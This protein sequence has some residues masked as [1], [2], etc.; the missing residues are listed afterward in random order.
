[1]PAVPYMMAITRNG[2]TAYVICD[3][4]AA[5]GAPQVVVPIS[6]R[7]NTAGKPI[8]TGESEIPVDIAVRP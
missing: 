4:P 5:A 2:A 6:T 7:T 1:M 8:S 3:G